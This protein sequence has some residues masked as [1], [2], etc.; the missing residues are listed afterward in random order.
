MDTN[1]YNNS[2]FSDEQKDKIWGSAFE[3][4]DAKRAAASQAK[5][6]L[7]TQRRMQRDFR[8][9]LRK[10]DYAK[11]NSVLM[12]MD[13]AG[14]S[15]GINLSP[16]GG[17]GI[18]GSEVFGTEVENEW[19][20]GNAMSRWIGRNDGQQGPFTDTNIE[21][22]APGE[23]GSV[24]AGP[25]A[26]DQQGSVLDGPPTPVKALVKTDKPKLDD[27]VFEPGKAT[28][29]PFISEGIDPSVFRGIDQKAPDA[30]AKNVEAELAF[31]DDPRSKDFGFDEKALKKRQAKLVALGKKANLNP[32][33]AEDAIR[34]YKIYQEK[35]SKAKGGIAFNPPVRTNGSEVDDIFGTALA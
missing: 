19:E 8:R 5:V 29:D 28:D 14:Q 26:P 20:K 9:A 10:D 2:M 23:Q 6:G 30:F 12:A 24:L 27:S 16:F 15:A 1:Q 13:R 21:T 3:V 31:W 11:A 33:E 32:G 35:L 22:P 17:G 7:N 18:R 25:P 4:R 34:L